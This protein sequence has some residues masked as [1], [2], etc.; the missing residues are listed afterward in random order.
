MDHSYL[1]LGGMLTFTG[2]IIA[3]YQLVKPPLLADL[4]AI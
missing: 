4:E 2:L 3:A 1:S